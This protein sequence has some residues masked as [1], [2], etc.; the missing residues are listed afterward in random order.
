[1]VSLLDE[2]LFKLSLNPGHSIQLDE[3]VNSPF[4]S[5]SPLRLGSGMILQA[6]LIPASQGPLC[7]SRAEEGFA[8]ADAALR[9]EIASRDPDCWQRMQVRRKFMREQIGVDLDESV[10]PLSNTPG[11]LPPYA[12]C[13]EKALTCRATGRS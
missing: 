6:D 3:W 9:D 7:S 1:M 5:E 4:F 10:L 8:L 11:W 12:L 13:L 2:R